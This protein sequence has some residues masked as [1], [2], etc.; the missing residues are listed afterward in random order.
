ML[1]CLDDL[2]NELFK[3]GNYLR[4]ITFS[5]ITSLDKSASWRL[6]RA[7]ILGIND[8]VTESGY[9]ITTR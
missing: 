9:I 8:I 6:L 1:P 2:T 5:F 7:V 3:G 4:I